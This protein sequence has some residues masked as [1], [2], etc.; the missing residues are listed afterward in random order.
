MKRYAA[1]SPGFTLIEIL[2]VITIIGVL[3]A[4]I[5]TNFVGVRE[6]GRDGKRK[7]DLKQIQTALEIYRADRASYPTTSSFPS[8]GSSFT[9]GTSEYMQRVPCDPLGVSV[10]YSYVSDGGRYCLRACLEN[11][12]DPDRDTQAPSCPGTLAS[13][14]I[15][16]T[17]RNP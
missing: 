10:S 11:T 4:L 1:F 15:N 16:H 17:V 12:R 13:C 9:A 8:C 7:S 6:R 2:I 3:A 5:L 14:T